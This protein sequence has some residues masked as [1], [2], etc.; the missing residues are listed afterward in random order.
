MSSTRHVILGAAALIVF[1]CSHPAV[2]QPA[3]ASPRVFDN[4]SLF[5]GPDGSKQPQDLGINANMGVR[6]GANWGV[7]I[8]DSA[9]LG[10]QVGV[11]F[12][13]SDAAVNVLD[14]ISS[15]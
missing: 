9:K 3:S 8:V 1:V 13:W 7:P 12:N 10:V 2:A 5:A 15:T 14:Q 6:F 4:L 11:G